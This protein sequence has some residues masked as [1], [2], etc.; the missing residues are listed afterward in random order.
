[1]LEFDA[2]SALLANPHSYFV[3][4]VE[5]TGTSEAEYLRTLANGVDVK[6]RLEAP[7]A[8][9]DDQIVLESSERDPLLV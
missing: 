7:S 1:M 6:M 3:S 2:P 9:A 4:L 8:D 5:Q